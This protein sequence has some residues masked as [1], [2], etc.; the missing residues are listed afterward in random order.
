MGNPLAPTLA[1]FFLG[2]QET[3]LFEGETTDTDHPAF[4]VRYVDD[5]FCV[6]RGN[7]KFE[8]FLSKLNA[9]HGNLK[10]THEF[11][12]KAMPFLDIKVSLNDNKLQTTVFRKK[13][14]HRCSSPL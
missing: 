1:N 11:G 2:H 14:E 8:N 10:F 9:L 3:L 6:F 5:V 12:G 13:N 4:Y 7:A